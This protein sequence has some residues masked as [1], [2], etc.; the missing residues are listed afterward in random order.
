MRG[1]SDI[2]SS[3]KSID[4][5][6]ARL[7]DHMQRCR[8][9]I[10]LSTP[11]L[12]TIEKDVAVY[13]SHSSCDANA[14]FLRSKI[15]EFTRKGFWMVFPYRTTRDNPNLRLSPTG[16]FPQGDRHGRLIIDYT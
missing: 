2:S 12:S 10:L 4:H 8:V 14:W 15:E 6:A 1:V 11:P 16:L 13:G 9:P 5:G 3:V 7:S